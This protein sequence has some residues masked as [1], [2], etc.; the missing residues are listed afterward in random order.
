MAADP[1]SPRQFLLD[2]LDAYN[3]AAW[4]EL[5]AFV[6]DDYVH[7]NNELELSLANFK[8]GAN[9]FRTAMP[10]FRIDVDELIVEGDL[11][12]ARFTATGTH[13]GS[14]FGEEVTG[15][16]VR[17]RGQIFYRLRD[18]RIAADWEAMDEHALR[19]QVGA[20]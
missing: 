8:Y 12:A 4:D 7:H 6:T 18:G 15:K 17:L 9:W 20:A 11:A 1:A 14:L 16:P 3:R 5:D 10:D 19:Q 13:E 2:Y